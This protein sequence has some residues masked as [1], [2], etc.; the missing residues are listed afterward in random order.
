MYSVFHNSLAYF[1]K[2]LPNYHYSFYLTR[3]SP[4]PCSC[5]CLTIDVSTD[6]RVRVRVRCLGP[7]RRAETLNRISFLDGRGNIHMTH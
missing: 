2:G 6:I 5:I 3:S 7:E 4:L 1:L